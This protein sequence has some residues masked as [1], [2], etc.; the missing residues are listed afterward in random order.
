[1]VDFFV[2][3]LVLLKKINLRVVG[4]FLSV[5]AWLFRGHADVSLE[6]FLEQGSYVKSSC[7]LS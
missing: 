4:C 6:L 2:H 3:C 5:P 1:M 7:S